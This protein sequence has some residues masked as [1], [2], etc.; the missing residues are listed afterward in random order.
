MLVK[1]I[2]KK[3]GTISSNVPILVPS[4]EVHYFDTRPGLEPGT[5]CNY[6]YLRDKHGICHQHVQGPVL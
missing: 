5:F 3:V 2:I 4:N 6:V 1:M